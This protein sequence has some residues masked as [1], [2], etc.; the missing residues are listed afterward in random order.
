MLI[1]IEN[2]GTNK[3]FFFL[4]GRI[5]KMLLI[6]KIDL[7]PNPKGYIYLPVYLNNRILH[8]GKQIVVPGP[9]ISVKEKKDN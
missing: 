5:R 6:N 1:F 2:V 3:V 4:M 7:K 9:I 8:I